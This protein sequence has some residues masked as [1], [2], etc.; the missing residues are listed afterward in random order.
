MWLFKYHTQAPDS[1]DTL[2]NYV[3][4]ITLAPVRYLQARY[5]AMSVKG[6]FDDTTSKMYDMLENNSLKLSEKS[7][8]HLATAAKLSSLCQPPQNQFQNNQQGRLKNQQG[9]GNRFNQRKNNYQ[10]GCQGRN[11]DAF[12]RFANKQ[13]PQRKQNTNDQASENSKD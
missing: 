6:N 7:Y 12:S 2:V 5:G 13:F 11:Q 9:T 8:G 3:Y 10:G 1:L 4:M